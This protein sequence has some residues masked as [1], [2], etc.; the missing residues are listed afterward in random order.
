MP[1]VLELPSI[2]QILTE[3]IAKVYRKVAKRT[4]APYII[5]EVLIDEVPLLIF[6]ATHILEVGEEVGTLLVL[7]KKVKLLIHEGLHSDTA[8][9]FSLI[10]HIYIETPPHLILW[11]SIDIDAQILP[12]AHLHRFRVS[13]RWIVVQ[14]KGDTSVGNFSLS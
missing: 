4:L 6:S 8:D 14:I 12:S 11:S 2:Q 7:I 10:E 1:F 5:V 3:A 9:S 13:N